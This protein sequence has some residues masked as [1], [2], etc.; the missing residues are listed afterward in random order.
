M[1]GVQ[2]IARKR[3]GLVKISLDLFQKRFRLFKIPL[4]LFLGESGGVEYKE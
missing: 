3:L 2:M 1:D 4:R